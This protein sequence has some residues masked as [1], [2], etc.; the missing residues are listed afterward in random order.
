MSTVAFHDG[1]PIFVGV[2]HFR[3][4]T[5]PTYFLGATQLRQRNP[6]F[7]DPPKWIISSENTP[8]LVADLAI[9]LLFA[10]VLVAKHSTTS[11]RQLLAIQEP[12]KY[13]SCIT[14]N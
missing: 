5:K 2:R 10:F 11:R 6:R 9:I 1:V 8:V 14:V 4:P 3:T 7:S 12:G 13:Y